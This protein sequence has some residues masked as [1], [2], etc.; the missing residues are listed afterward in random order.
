MYVIRSTILHYGNSVNHIVASGFHIA[1][2]DMVK[3]Q[4]A[5]YI[6]VSCKADEITWILCGLD[7]QIS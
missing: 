4:F 7:L 6:S 3:V 5:H 1:R 2:P